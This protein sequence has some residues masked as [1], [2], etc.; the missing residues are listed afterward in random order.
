VG[1]EDGRIIANPGQMAKRLQNTAQPLSKRNI[2]NRIISPQAKQ[3]LSEKQSSKVQIT[4]I[5]V[6][7][8]ARQNLQAILA[9]R[10]MPEAN[11]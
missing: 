6:K 11:V 4:N 8:S 5:N 3:E 9:N 7:A 1:P 10:N 2:H